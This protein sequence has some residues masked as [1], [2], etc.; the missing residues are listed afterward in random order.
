ML[1]LDFVCPL[2][3]ADGYIDPLLDALRAQEEIEIASGVFAITDTG[4]DLSY[5]TGKITEAGYTYFTLP[6]EEFSHSLTRARALEDYCTSDLVVMMSQDIVITSPTTLY[7]L[8]KRVEGR[9]VF[10]YGRQTVG[11]NSIEKYIRNKNYGETSFTVGKEDVER[12]QLGAFFASDAFSC[13]HRPTYL[14][15]GGYDGIPMMMNEDMYYAKKVID[16]GYLKAYVAEASVEH[17]H[18]Y[19]LRQL[20]RRYYETGVWF[21]EH[22]EFN[23]YSTTDSGVK[24]ALSVLGQALRQFNIPV[25]FRLLPDMAARYLGLRAGKRAARRKEKQ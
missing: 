4:E 21:V 10:A 23:G 18:R 22:P 11:R 17:S 2:Y 13:Y 24:L 9:V 20:Y 3:R 19:K 6:P 12:L 1:K 15:L 16:A 5:V 14:A 7:D 8:A 25:L